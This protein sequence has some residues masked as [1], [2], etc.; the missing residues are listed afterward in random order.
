MADEREELPDG[1]HQ[2]TTEDMGGRQFLTHERVAQ[3]AATNPH[4]SSM[5]ANLCILLKDEAWEGAMYVD[6]AT[7]GG[8]PT[9]VVSVRITREQAIENGLT[10]PD[11][12]DLILTPLFVGIN[13]TI[14]KS[15]DARDNVTVVRK[16][17]H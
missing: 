16:K 17:D 7:T 13:R 4:I 3:E 1:M 11:G 5:F 12:M 14:S 6:L 10:P 9:L 15:I 8:E 2:V